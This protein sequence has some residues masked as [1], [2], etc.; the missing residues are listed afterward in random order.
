MLWGSRL[1]VLVAVVAGL[2]LVVGAA[3]LAT[4]D[5]VYLVGLLLQ[6]GEPA[7]GYEARG[8][9]RD[10]IVTVI[11]KVLDEYLISAILIIFPWGLYELF[12]GK[13]DAAEGSE[14][15]SR[16]LYV[17]SIDDLKDKVVRLILLI[18]AIE[19]FQRALQLRYGSSL[20]LM[21]LA[22]G[23]LPVSGAFYLIGR[24]G[25]HGQSPGSSPDN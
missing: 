12:V 18:L 15:A 2:L 16:L 19:F 13:I 1:L 21:Y 17:R 25:G 20:D 5:V 4:V 11:A 24:R 14:T 23:I 9:L 6:Y 7:L 22:G 3:Y 8:E 10:G